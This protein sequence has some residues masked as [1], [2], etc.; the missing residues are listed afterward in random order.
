MFERYTEKA[1]RTVFFARYEASQ[2]GSPVIDTEHLLLGVLREDKELVRHVLLKVDFES[3]HREIS[4]RITK[5]DSFP[6]SVGLPLSEHAKR[7]LIHSATEANRLNH[8]HIGTAHLLLG[9]MVE[10]EFASSQFLARFGVS[11]DSLRKKVEAR[12][13]PPSALPSVPIHPRFHQPPAPPNR[14]EL[15]GVRW[16]LD[17]IRSAHARLCQSPWHW[18]RRRWKSQDVV[19][20]K[21]GKRFSFDMR[22]A[23]RQSGE[24]VRSKGGWKK[25][26]CAI[27]TWDLFESDDP[28]RSLGYTNGRDWVC[29]DCYEKFIAGNFF[30]SPYTDIT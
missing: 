10:K 2:F 8:R 24:F 28:A 18:E 5:G 15:H 20:T 22:L 25:D 27:C 14:I 1:R 6:T 3:A 13:D 11:L 4:S 12:G 17:Q 29:T 19:T 9:L 7:A 26:R 21:D 23:R 30:G 16:N